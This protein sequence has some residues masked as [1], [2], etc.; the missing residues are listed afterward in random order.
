LDFNR[1]LLVQHMSNNEVIRAS[2]LPSYVFDGGRLVE[3]QTSPEFL[4]RVKNALLEFLQMNG[5]NPDSVLFSGYESL[6]SNKAEYSPPDP[7]EKLESMNEYIPEY[8]EDFDDDDLQDDELY[9]DEQDNDIPTYYFGDINAIVP[10]DDVMSSP[11]T[12][13]LDGALGIYNRREL[14]ELG[15]N[16]SDITCLD[17]Y[18]IT[19]ENLEKAKIA[20]VYLPE[21]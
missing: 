16:T 3:S 14:E 10:N 12:Y 13:A 11:V 18:Q 4:N 17:T 8:D 7:S 5:I 21:A 20:E 9:G 2:I 15:I 19:P 6:N 1:V